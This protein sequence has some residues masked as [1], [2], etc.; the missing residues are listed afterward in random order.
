MTTHITIHGNLTGDPETRFTP[1]GKAVATL[2]VA[3]NKR[4]RQP[5]GTWTDDG[6]DFYRV[7]AWN[8]LAENI[9]DSLRKGD[10]VLVH[11]RIESRDW[12]DRDGNK[13]TSWEIT[14]DEVGASLQWATVSIQRASSGQQ[15]QSRGPAGAD[16]WAATQ[17][18]EPP[19]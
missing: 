15:R 8:K 1:S 11:G 9:T 3:V 18:D 13:R 17:T 4:A 16:P 12:E 2:T 14:A 5:D 6:A 7:Q 19:F 10:R